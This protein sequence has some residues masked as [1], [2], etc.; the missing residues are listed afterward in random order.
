VEKEQQERLF[1]QACRSLDAMA[2]DTS[3]HLDHIIVN[4]QAVHDHVAWH[5]EHVR[6]LESRQDPQIEIMALREELIER[7]QEVIELRVSLDQ[8]VANG[9]WHHV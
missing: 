4:L 8:A 9:G 5:L 3:C 1:E 7:E 2:E 6:F